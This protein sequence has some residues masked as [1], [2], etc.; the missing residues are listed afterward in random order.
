MTKSQTNFCDLMIKTVTTTRS[1]D[2]VKFNI[3]RQKILTFVVIF[4]CIHLLLLSA[5]LFRGLSVTRATRRV[6]ELILDAAPPPTGTPCHTC[7]TSPLVEAKRLQCSPSSCS[8]T[9]KS[10][11][12]SETQKLQQEFGGNSRPPWFSRNMWELQ[13]QK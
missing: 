12:T 2:V 6:S 9:V 3:L 8:F 11:R 13:I 4:N 7:F 10:S 1:W 5:L